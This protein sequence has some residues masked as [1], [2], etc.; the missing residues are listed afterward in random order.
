MVLDTC[1]SHDSYRLSPQKSEI[2]YFLH[3]VF[4]FRRCSPYRVCE[5]QVKNLWPK[6]STTL[7]YIRGNWG[8]RKWSELPPIIKLLT[9][10]RDSNTVLMTPLLA[11]FSLC[12]SVDLYV[13]FSF[14]LLHAEP[15]KAN[16]RRNWQNEDYVGHTPPPVFK[17][18]IQKTQ[19]ETTQKH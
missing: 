11:L 4:N 15:H 14:P 19:A 13:S 12:L 2:T 5:L 10:K 16:C 17:P 7:F 9:L 18:F 1:W 6:N 3:F 8:P